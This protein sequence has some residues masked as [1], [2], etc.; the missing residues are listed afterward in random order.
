IVKWRGE[1][2]PGRKVTRVVKCGSASCVQPLVNHFFRHRNVRRTRLIRFPASSLFAAPRPFQ[3]RCSF[4]EADASQS[5]WVDG[6]RRFWLSRVFQQV[7]DVDS[8]V[9][10]LKID[11]RIEGAF[12]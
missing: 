11:K 8:S 1:I 5:S 12:L 2:C 4:A 10:K 9:C 3:G 6:Q 7:K